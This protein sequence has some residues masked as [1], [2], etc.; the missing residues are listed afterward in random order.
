MKHPSPTALKLEVT[1]GA[2]AIVGRN[3]SLKPG[4]LVGPRAVIGEVFPAGGTY[5]P[6]QIVTPRQNLEIW[7]R[8]C[9]S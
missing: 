9:Q 5:E 6:D 2:Y 3:R 7:P 8:R 1:F 4:R